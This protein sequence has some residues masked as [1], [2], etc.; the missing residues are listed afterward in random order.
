MSLIYDGVS[1]KDF[2]FTD[3]RID[4]M[5]Y[6]ARYVHPDTIEDVVEHYPRKKWSKCFSK[7]IREEVVVKPWCHTTACEEKFP[8]DV[9]H[10]ELMEPY[11]AL[12]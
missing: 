12:E 3:I 10:N 7:K 5:G 1:K 4:N 11:D 2:F 8:R 6:R 9:E